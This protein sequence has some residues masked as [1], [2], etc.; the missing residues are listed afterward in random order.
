M[1][2]NSVKRKFTEAL[3]GLVEQVKRD[4]SVLAAILC[5][6][7]SHDAVWLIDKAHKFFVTR[8]D[9]DYT[10]LWLLYAAVP[11]AQ[12]EVIGAGLLLDR[13]VL[14]QAAKLNPAFFKVV[15]SDLLNAKKTRK[16]VQA[17][18]DA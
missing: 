16:A 6:S 2:D 3:G 12:V 9:L 15:Y 7:L 10:A 5:G 4:R 13:E 14:P 17:A 8:G 1:D 18:L 11:L